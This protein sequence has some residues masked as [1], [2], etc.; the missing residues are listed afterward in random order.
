MPDWTKIREP[1]QQHCPWLKLGDAFDDG[2][3]WIRKS[4][5]YILD[6]MGGPINGKLEVCVIEHD[7]R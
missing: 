1:A 7:I 5:E 4:R 2:Q 6:A 3:R